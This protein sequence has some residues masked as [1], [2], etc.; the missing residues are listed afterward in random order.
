MRNSIKF[1]VAIL[2]LAAAASCKTVADTAGSSKVYL[3]GVA[4][5]G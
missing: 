4:G 2:T 3:V 5:G 1:G